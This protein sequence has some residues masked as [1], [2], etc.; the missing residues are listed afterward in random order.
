MRQ[1]IR[2]AQAFY[3]TGSDRPTA[4]APTIVFIHGAGFDHSVWVMQARYFA[5][6]GYQVIAPDLPAHGR[7]AGTALRSIEDMADWVAE[8]WDA[9][10]AGPGTVVGHSM[11]SL[12][13]A[14]LATRHPQRVEKIALLGTSLPMP[15]GA[16]LLEAAADDHHA[17]FEMANTWSHSTAGSFGAAQ[18]PGLSNLVSGERWL[19]R[20]APGVYHADL[21]ACNDFQGSIDV[22]DKPVLII[23]GSADRMTPVKAGLDVARHMPRARTVV[24]PGCGHAMMSEQPNAVLDALAEFV[25]G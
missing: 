21:S 19:E 12:I 25:C 16:A 13:A 22:G 4:D 6:H 8:L 7:S 9:I 11:G 3:G 20:M 10:G 1:E 18:V 2:G 15:V 23:A 24:L 14:V 5:R 17:A